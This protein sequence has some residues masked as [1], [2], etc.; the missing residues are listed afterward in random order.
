MCIVDGK[1]HFPESVC[2]AEGPD[3]CELAQ[4]PRYRKGPDVCF[5]NNENVR[6]NHTSAFV[7]R[8]LLETALLVRLYSWP[9]SILSGF[10]LHCAFCKDSK[11][12]WLPALF[13]LII[14][15]LYLFIFCI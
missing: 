15:S 13:S 4:N 2:S 5:D 14:Y 9:L 7:Q 3:P 12:C 11:Y 6:H 1:S 10:H 8:I